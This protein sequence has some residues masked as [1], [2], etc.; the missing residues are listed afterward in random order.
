MTA[1]VHTP[2]GTASPLKLDDPSTWTNSR[3]P[4]FLVQALPATGEHQRPAVRWD[5]CSSRLAAA[6]AEGLP[7]HLVDPCRGTDSAALHGVVLDRA[8][9]LHAANAHYLHPILGVRRWTSHLRAQYA[10]DLTLEI[11]AHVG[12]PGTWTLTLEDYEPI[13]EAAVTI[14]RTGYDHLVGELGV[15]PRY[16]TTS[17]T[18]MGARLDVDWRAFGPRRCWMV[19]AIVRHLETRLFPEGFTTI[20][21]RLKD[22]VARRRAH[23]E[24]T[25]EVRVH[26]ELDTRMFE[27]SDRVRL[28]GASRGGTLRAIGSLH[29][30]SSNRIMWVR[31]TPVPHEAFRPEHAARLTK[32][33]RNHVGPSPEHFEL[34]ELFASSWLRRQPAYR[35]PRGDSLIEANPQFS[36]GLV[37]AFDQASDI[38]DRLGIPALVRARDSA[39]LRSARDPGPAG[40]EITPEIVRAVAARLDGGAVD[41]GGY[42]RIVC[43]ECGDQAR[44][45][46]LFLDTGGFQCF[47][48]N[49][50]GPIGVVQ[51]ARLAGCVDLVPV[52]RHSTSS[53]RRIHL[54]ACDDGVSEPDWT[55]DRVEA[56]IVETVVEARAAQ[57]D[58]LRAAL[59]HRDEWDLLVLRS[60]TGAGKTTMAEDAVAE[61]GLLSR[62]F[63]ARAEGR[64]RFLEVLQP[65]RAVD[66]RQ[67]GVNCDNP[68]LAQAVT[69]GMPSYEVCGPACEYHTGCRYLAQFEG[70]EGHH[71]ALLHAHLPHAELRKFGGNGDLHGPDAD[72]AIV[73]ENP[74]AQCFET[75]DLDAQDLDRM[76][77]V[78]DWTDP[79]TD[80]LV[81]VLRADGP[82]DFLGS[83]IEDLEQGMSLD[84]SV[85]TWIAT[86]PAI[87]RL[88]DRLIEVLRPEAMMVAQRRTVGLRPKR[89]GKRDETTVFNV[90]ADAELRVV[91]GDDRVLLEALGALDDAAVGR[92]VSSAKALFHENGPASG[93][94]PKM[95][96]PLLVEA[97]RDLVTGLEPVAPVHLVHDHKTDRWVVRLTKT[98]DMWPGQTIL[99]S[100]TITP[101]QVKLAFW[102]KRTWV[103]APT[104]RARE[105]R[106]LIADRSYSQ[107][108]LKDPKEWKRVVETVRALIERERQRTRMA[109]AVIGNSKVM[110]RFLDELLGGLP[111]TL[112]MPWLRGKRDDCFEELRKLCEPFGVLPGYAGGVAG[113]NAFV[114]TL[115]G[116]TR[117][118]RSLVVLGNILPRLA[119]FAAAHRGVFSAVGATDED[120]EIEGFGVSVKRP[121]DWTIV[122]RTSAIPGTER[123]EAP[124]RTVK[125]ISNMMG[126][127]DHR[128]Q[129]LLH[130]SYQ[131]ELVQI[132][133]RLRGVIGDPD[134]IQ[135]R[136]YIVAGLA[137]PGFG[138][139]VV[140][141]LDQLRAELGFDEEAKCPT[142]PV[143]VDIDKVAAAVKLRG[144]GETLRR[145]TV[146][147]FA[148]GVRLAGASPWASAMRLAEAAMVKAGYAVTDAHRAR[149]REAISGRDPV[150]GGPWV[151]DLD[152]MLSE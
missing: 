29:S 97:L 45:A 127:A 151:R 47:R 20:E 108:Q 28:D 60:P 131:A 10:V 95:A 69:V 68:K 24:P 54:D 27:G 144:T 19:A 105:K 137:I 73:D 8:S 149:A 66:G 104:V 79:T 78:P 56:P 93:R 147:L 123:G 112:K 116:V 58:F 15:D 86:T 146:S 11:D 103:F 94:T 35:E 122:R 22:A 26:V 25:D 39:T 23:H 32:V 80:E 133:G 3:A 152:E 118:V 125:A 101:L 85:L 75:I 128:A 74:W 91:L 77:T 17:V 40:Y 130:A 36:H 126:F 106:I 4:T 136:A 64:R 76:R 41:R 16:I 13:I 96:L 148:G 52:R 100:A 72:I 37:T 46:K 115:D 141:G 49:P 21:A 48:C 143:T 70:A 71:L 84:T 114:A 50:S 87:D 9:A 111:Q 102:S 138:M 18:R 90:L 83:S 88:L 63:Y 43:P 139:D 140:I 7:V 99:C 135:A 150:P 134:G 14:G 62:G 38:V 117:F 30:A 12:Y 1:P 34:P 113:S 129:D 142:K 31:S 61:S 121:V 51:L 2:E 110:N 124:T 6:E 119:D 42:F 5:P 98:R 57:G 67:P 33:S 55:A 107:T 132:V 145:L 109:V 81:A 53:V 120:E 82:N 92:W 65:S 44:S 59:R 89:R